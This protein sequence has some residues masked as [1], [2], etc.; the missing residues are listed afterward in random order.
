MMKMKF[1]KFLVKFYLKCKIFVKF[2]VKFEYK[3]LAHMFKILQREIKFYIKRKISQMDK[4]LN[5]VQNT[6][7]LHIQIC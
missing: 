6:S 5:I 4:I 3:I 7:Y 2:I 1:L